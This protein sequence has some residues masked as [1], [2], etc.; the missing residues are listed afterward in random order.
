MKYYIITTCLFLISVVMC[1]QDILD[2]RMCDV[3]NGKVKAITTTSPEM[4][5]S[6][7]KFSPNGKISS[8]KNATISVEYDWIS[9][10]ELKLKFSSTQGVE[11]FYI[12][13]NEY[14]KDFYDFD[15]GENNRKIWFRENGSI[16]KDE[17]T[18]NGNKKYTTYHYRSTTDLYPYKIE[19][20]MGE[21]LQTI[22]VN[23]DR[24]DSM[25]N[26]IE[27]TYSCNGITIQGKRVITYYE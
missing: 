6:E 7:M 26:V 22:Y 8:L 10:E 14:R 15:V 1:G 25:G 27:F 18:I 24:C 4:M 23:I 20:R 13:I 9:N 21:Q 12:Y 19:I 3:Y 2:S 11:Y 17:V 5:Q 16:D